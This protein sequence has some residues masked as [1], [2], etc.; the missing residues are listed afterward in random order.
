MYSLKDEKNILTDQLKHPNFKNKLMI[1]LAM[2]K[3]HFN[4]KFGQILSKLKKII[5]QGS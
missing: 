4:E 5:Y 2:I 3:K 1:Q